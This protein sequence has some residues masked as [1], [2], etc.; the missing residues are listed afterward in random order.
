[1]IG[2]K[3]IGDANKTY[4]HPFKLWTV[5]SG[6]YAEEERVFVGMLKKL[7]EKEG[8]RLILAGDFNSNL[9]P[10]RRCVCARVKET[11]EDMQEK[12]EL[13]ILNDYDRRTTAK[14]TIIDLAVS[15]GKME[16]RTRH[17]H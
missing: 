3:I 14:G 16:R 8:E 9:V 11:L 13:T 6:P 5:Y 2:V 10:G 17:T 1:M 12:G 15:M 4:G 7:Y